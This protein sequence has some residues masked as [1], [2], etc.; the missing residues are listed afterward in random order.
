MAN[1]FFAMICIFVPLIIIYYEKY[2]KSE[3]INNYG[4]ELMNFSSLGLLKDIKI[5]FLKKLGTIT[6]N[7]LYVDK[8]YTNDQIYFSKD[9]D[10]N[11]INI[12]RMLDISMLCNNAKY[13]IDN[14]W[15]KGD[16]F[17]IAFKICS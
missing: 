14:N 15:S 1:S 8:I 13:N 3:L 7:E 17:E 6:K 5:L 2:I 4:I 16:I 9:A 11:D 10:V 12:R